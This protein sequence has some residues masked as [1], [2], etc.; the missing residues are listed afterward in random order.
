MSKNELCKSTGGRRWRLD[1]CLRLA[2]IR[3]GGNCGGFVI[4]I[5][6][7]GV[8]YIYVGY[9]QVVVTKDTKW[10]KNIQK[11]EKKFKKAVVFTIDRAT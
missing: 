3:A 7:G 2:V 11:S 10:P 5:Y 9:G 1:P 4:N 8:G 6:E